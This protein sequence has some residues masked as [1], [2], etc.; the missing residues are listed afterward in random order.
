MIKISKKEKYPFDKN[1]SNLFT[2]HSPVSRI[3]I[4][5]NVSRLSLLY[6]PPQKN[7]RP[8]MKILTRK[9]LRDQFDRDTQ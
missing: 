9:I 8:S 3:L 2:Y 4:F 1:S 6:K 5:S 7:V